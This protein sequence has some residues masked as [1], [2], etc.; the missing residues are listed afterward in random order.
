[1]SLKIPLEENNPFF[2]RLLKTVQ[3]QE[4]MANA[5]TAVFKASYRA[6]ILSLDFD[7]ESSSDLNDT[8]KIQLQLTKNPAP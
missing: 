8:V 5:I 6:E 1:M 7:S 2:E 4:A 3:L